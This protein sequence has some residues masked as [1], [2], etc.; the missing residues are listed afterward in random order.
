MAHE[1]AS[2]TG[3]IPQFPASNSAMQVKQM[4]VGR[5]SSLTTFRMARVFR[6]HIYAVFLLANA[7]DNPHRSIIAWRRFVIVQLEFGTAVTPAITICSGVDLDPLSC[8]SSK[9]RS[10]HRSDLVFKEI[11]R[12]C[13]ASRMTSGM[14]ETP[15][16][17][18]PA[19]DGS[20]NSPRLGSR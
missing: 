15:D 4:R 5:L 11:D 2:S 1:A 7:N 14:E 18:M 13:T 10:S 20:V 17:E 19:P 8:K 3:M 16:V 6:V 9:G 12:S